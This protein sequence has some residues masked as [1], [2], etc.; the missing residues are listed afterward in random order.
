MTVPS[1]AEVTY[2][3]A[4][5][6]TGNTRSA[7][8][9][10]PTTRRRARRRRAGRRPRQQRRRPRRRRDVDLLVRP[11]R[12]DRRVINTATVTGTPLN[13]VSRDAPV[14][15]S[16]PGGDRRP[17]PAEVEVVNP[18]IDLTKTADP[19]VVLLDP[20]TPVPPEPVTYTFAAT[21]TGDAP[22]NRP[23]ATTQGPA[24]PTP[25]GSTDRHC[26]ESRDLRQR[27]HDDNDLLDPGETWKFTLSRSRS[28]QPT[29]QHRRDHRPAVATPTAT[30]CRASTRSTTA[31]RRSSTSSTPASRSS[32]PRCA[33]WSSTPTPTPVAGPDVPTRGRPSTS[34]RSP[35]PAT[36]RSTWTPAA[37]RRHL[38]AAGRSSSGDTNGD[39]LLDPDEVWEYTLR[40]DARTRAGA[41][42]RRST[43]DMSGL[44]DEHGRPS[45]ACPFFDGAPGARQVRRQ[46][47]TPPRCTVIEPG[48]TLTKTASAE[49]V[50]VDGRRDLHV[51]R[52]PTPATSGSI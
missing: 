43:G 8:S 2:T 33:A 12:P 31:P 18:D 11:P 1:G 4:A 46:P 41:T 26:D 35:T 40:D 30:R 51:R 24:R 36:S 37:D 15:G 7:P 16:Q 34:T 9:R 17:T 49:V 27:R 47:P 45:P 13:P 44:V 25:G 20:A 38:R 22:L 29:R 50:R 42:P 52:R 6:N 23:G 48:L 39:G 14:P 19:D 10:S 28:T 5:T 3:Y 32:R 21:N